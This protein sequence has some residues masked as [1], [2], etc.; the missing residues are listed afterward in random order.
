MAPLLRGPG[1]RDSSQVSR[2][3]AALA[4]HAGSRDQGQPAPPVAEVKRGCLPQY[5][6]QAAAAAAAAE[7]LP[8]VPN[9]PW[10]AVLL[11]PSHHLP[12]LGT[13]PN[14]HTNKG[15]HLTSATLC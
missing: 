15:T 1:P 8:D 12:H 6:A 3:S 9:P 2:P 7:T 10:P 11:T 14:S 5:L 13:P 4:P